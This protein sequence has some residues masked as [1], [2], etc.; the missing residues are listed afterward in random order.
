MGLLASPRPDMVVVSRAARGAAWIN[1]EPAGGGRAR[2]PGTGRA[3]PRTAPLPVRGGEGP[4]RGAVV[5]PSGG[6]G[7]VPA[8]GAP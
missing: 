2:Q 5:A 8:T 4:V 3:V 1:G 6:R 7:T